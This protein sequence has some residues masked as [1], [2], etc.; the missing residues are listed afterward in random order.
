MHRQRYIKK[1]PNYVPMEY[2][3]RF[4]IIYDKMA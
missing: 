2:L 4:E 3:R 1:T